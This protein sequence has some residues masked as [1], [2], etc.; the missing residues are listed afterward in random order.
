MDTKING[1]EF[2]DLAPQRYYAPPNSW[3]IE[4]RK[5]LVNQR[6]FSGE[7]YG[8]L[9]RD[10]ALYRFV[11][12]NDG[13]M[14]LLGRSKSKKTNDYLNKIDHVP[15][16]QKFFDKLPNGTCLLGELYLPSDEQA[17]TTTAIMNSLTPR[18]VKKQ[19]KEPLTYYVFDILA[20]D[21]VNM[22]DY[23]LV[24][25]I[26]ELN[27]MWRTYPSEFVEYAEYFSGKELWDKL[28][29]YLADGNEGIVITNGTSPYRPGKRSTKDTLK[30]KKELQDTIDT[31]I[32]GA[33]PATKEY[34]GKEIETWPY[35][36]DE[37]TNKKVYGSFF[38]DYYDGAPYQPITKNYYNGWAGSLKLGVYKDD[39]LVHVGNL[40]GITEEIKEKWKGYIGKVA[41]IT[42]MEIMDTGGIRHC[43]FIRWKDD[44]KPEECLMEQIQ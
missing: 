38:Q 44:K 24:D 8:A 18:A 37:R 43:K 40:S 7:W 33:N 17:K 34:T 31:V 41:E 15:H 30:I 23:S 4:K 10:G 5:E 12:Y 16:L 22:I 32:I 39:K 26:E 35:W 27:L 19:E 25:R 36:L 3:T 28:Q 13:T 11:K 29:S 42:A 9:K 14:E 6:I 2:H 1:Y 20:F 21:G